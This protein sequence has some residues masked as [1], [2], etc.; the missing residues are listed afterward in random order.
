MW[1]IYSDGPY[2]AS[3]VFDIELEASAVAKGIDG[4]FRSG[5]L[6]GKTVN[7][8]FYAKR[9]GLLDIREDALP[10]YFLVL[11]GPRPR[12]MTSRGEDRLWFIDWGFLFHAASL[13][14]H[15]R[16][17]AVKIGVAT[18]VIRQQWDLAEMYPTATN[19]TLTLDA[20]QRRLLELFSSEPCSAKTSAAIAEVAFN[21]P[22]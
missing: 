8:K 10:D 16:E 15:L 3:K 12:A 17:R 6:Q 19:T 18:G 20:N 21:A 14:L 22:E 2:I 5:L 9:E 1:Q 7:V 13:Q 4:R 11:A